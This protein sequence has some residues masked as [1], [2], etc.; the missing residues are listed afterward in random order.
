MKNVPVFP[1]AGAV[2]ASKSA[3]GR[4]VKMRFLRF[5]LVGSVGFLLDAVVLWG[6][7]ALGFAPLVARVFSYLAAATGTWLLNRRYTFDADPQLGLWREWTHYLAV[8]GLGGGI[9]YLCFALALMTL[10]AVR[11]QPVLGVALGSAV[12]LVFNYLANKHLVF[13]GEPMK[14]PAQ[15][16]K[17]W[18]IP[19]R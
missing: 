6:L 1:P 16:G 5:C 10:D 17:N 12:A 18:S 13:R 7:M 15:A 9:N 4:F 8:N 2:S 14:N 3:P 19:Q 11:A